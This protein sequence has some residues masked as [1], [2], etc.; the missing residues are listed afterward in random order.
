MNTNKYTADDGCRHNKNY[1]NKILGGSQFGYE[2]F[3]E[4]MATWDSDVHITLN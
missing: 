4:N 3:G 1:E 2:L